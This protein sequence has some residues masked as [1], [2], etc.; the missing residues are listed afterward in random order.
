MNETPLVLFVDDEQEQLNSLR[1]AFIDESFAARFVNSGAQALEFMNHTHVDVIVAD[2][3][4]P[5]M[6]GMELFDQVRLRYP[7][8]LCILLSGQPSIDP[9]E[10]S[11]MVRAV[12]RKEI[13]RFVAKST[14][15]DDTVRAVIL[16]A[17][18]LCQA[19]RRQTN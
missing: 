15:L 11:T 17:L 13:Y 19:S 6:S 5:A 16:E 8:T 1:R 9:S 4:M 14:H 7:D 3:H 2:Y 10:V 18:A 12:H